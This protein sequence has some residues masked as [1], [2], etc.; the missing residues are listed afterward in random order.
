MI[1]ARG[2]GRDDLQLHHTIQGVWGDVESSPRAWDLGPPSFK[3]GRCPKLESL[4]R[5]F[6]RNTKERLVL[7]RRQAP[8]SQESCLFSSMP[9]A[10]STMVAVEIP[11]VI[12]DHD[13]LSFV[14]STRAQYPETG[15]HF[16]KLTLKYVSQERPNESDS[17]RIRA[18]PLSGHSQPGAGG[19]GRLGGGAARGRLWTGSWMGEGLCV[20]HTGSKEICSKEA[21]QMR[22]GRASLHR[23]QVITSN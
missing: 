8:P 16:K 10:I 3:R 18:F 9:L 6:A 22:K 11:K 14:F 13:L 19:V 17:I 4:Y 15:Y 20:G 21:F 5:V 2:T 7:L 23:D 12:K 1:F